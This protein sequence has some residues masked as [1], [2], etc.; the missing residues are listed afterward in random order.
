MA[1]LAN[2]PA[3]AGVRLRAAD[4]L[5]APARVLL[6]AGKPLGEPIA[7]YGPFVMNTREQLEQAFAD[8]QRGAL[9]G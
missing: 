4:G 5:A 7:Q 3:A 8:F 6:V 1:I 9:V 2:D